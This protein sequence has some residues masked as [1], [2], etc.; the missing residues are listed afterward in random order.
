MSIYGSIYTLAGKQISSDHS[1]G[2]VAANAVVSL[3]ATGPLAKDFVEALWNLPVPSSE[4]E[5]YYGGLLYLMGLLH[6]SGGFQI[7]IAR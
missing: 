7:Y 4:G 6:C 5:R 2:L 3:A 1:A